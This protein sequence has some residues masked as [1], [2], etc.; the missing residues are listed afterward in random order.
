MKI[1]PILKMTNRLNDA[2]FIRLISGS[3]IPMKEGSCLKLLSMLF[4]EDFSC[5]RNDKA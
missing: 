4:N 2:S 1:S 3:V 5:R